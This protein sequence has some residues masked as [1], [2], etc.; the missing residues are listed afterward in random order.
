MELHLI[1]G[2][3]VLCGYISLVMPVVNAGHI[4]TFKREASG[5]LDILVWPTKTGDEQQ[6]LLLIK[7]GAADENADG[8]GIVIRS[9]TA[10]TG[11]GG[12]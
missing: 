7:E 9:A 6:T 3:M 8:N 12:D 2:A 4:R 11:L 10:H 5:L 1:T